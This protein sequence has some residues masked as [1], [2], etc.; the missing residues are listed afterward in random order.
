MQSTP[1]IRKLIVLYGLSTAALVGLL[2]FVEYQFF[3]RELSV[4]FYVAVLA[5]LFTGL[6]IWT[7]RR[8]TRPKIAIVDPTFHLD[9]R[10]LERAGISKREY[11]ILALIAKGFSN[12]EIADHLFVSVA[13]VKTHIS[14]LFSKLNV[15]RRTQAVQRAQELKLLSPTFGRFFPIH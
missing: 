6:G 15:H 9:E 7:G 1:S 2:K 8:L 12:Q 14:S 5:L 11:E 4:E 10:D 13:T 3:V